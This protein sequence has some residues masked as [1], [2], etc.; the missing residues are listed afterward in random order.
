MTELT[1]EEGLKHI[2][3]LDK[4]A[5]EQAKRRW[6]SVAKPLNSLGLLEEAIIKI[7]GIQKDSHVNLEKKA[8]V[9]CCGDNGIVEEGVTQTGQEVTGIVTQNFTKGESCVC[10]MAKQAGAAVL[11]IDLGVASE[12]SGTEK[13]FPDLDHQIRI[14]DRKISR[15]TRNFLY[16]PAME[17]R[18]AVQALETGILAA[19]H[20]KEKG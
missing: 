16:G 15:G 8:V 14:W 6:D 13:D 9:I 4:A 7:A 18:Q 3:D 5:M 12:L 17:R 1:L 11:P 2:Q 19:G 20:L 10:L